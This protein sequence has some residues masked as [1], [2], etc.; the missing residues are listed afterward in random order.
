VISPTEKFLPFD[1]PQIAQGLQK[2]ERP[3][4]LIGGG[5]SHSTI[6]EVLPELARLNI[7]LMTT[8][9]GADRVN[10]DYKNYFGRPNTWGQRYSNVLLQ[11]SDYIITIGT[12][13][14]LQQTGFNW[15]EFAPLARLIQVDIDPA[16]LE[17]GHPKVDVGIVMDANEFLP[18]LV[19]SI[20]KPIEIEPWL[21]F[22]HMVKQ[23]LPIIEKNTCGADFVSPYVLWNTIPQHFSSETIFIPSSSGGTFTTAYQAIALRESQKLI[24]NK[25]L[26][27]MGYGLSGAIGVALANPE[28]DV[29][30][31]EGDGGFAQNMQELGTVRAQN[32]NIT[33]FIFDNDGYASIRMTQKNYFG[34]EWVGCD[35]AT[36]V[37]M[38]DWQRLSKAFEIPYVEMSGQDLFSAEVL[39]KIRMAGPVFIRV[40]CDPTQ[41]YFPKIASRVTPSGTMASNP[42]HLMDPPLTG[43]VEQIVM[44]YLQKR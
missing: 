41:T 16:E 30:L 21:E 26:A 15:N 3:V 13:L 25:S 32:L 29:V 8:F 28:H 5:V 2:S 7:P 19:S 31:G 33:M 20:E 37:G 11:Q 17:K 40:I 10:D 34:G 4:I 12:R 24:S 14:G 42:L 18:R 1:V 22:C 27:S 9:N 39:E 36:Q 44:K 38:P 35:T 23:A 6:K 43:D